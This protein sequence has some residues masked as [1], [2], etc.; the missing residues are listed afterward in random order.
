MGGHVMRTSVQ[1]LLKQPLM[2]V[3]SRRSPSLGWLCQAG[4]LVA[5]L[6]R[7]HT[8]PSDVLCA[9]HV[10][11]SASCAKNSSYRKH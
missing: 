7:M 11:A 4:L 3:W 1:V 8:H 5:A 2:L 9:L 6:Q 10:L